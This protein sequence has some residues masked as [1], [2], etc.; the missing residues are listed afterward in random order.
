MK[1]KH[2]NRFAWRVKSL[3]VLGQ[4]DFSTRTKPSRKGGYDRKREN[5]QWRQGMDF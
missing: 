3:T 1:A 5:R 4:R 2:D